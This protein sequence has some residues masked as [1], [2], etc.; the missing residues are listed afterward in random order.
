MNDIQRAID[1]LDGVLFD[2]HVPGLNE[3]ECLVQAF[4]EVRLNE[5]RAV[6]A[7]IERRAESIQLPLCYNIDAAALV[8]LA[9]L[10]ER[11]EHLK[12]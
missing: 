6:V 3:R 1:L 12:P 4:T 2:V 11:G 10:I 7:W 8:E 9:S 5:R